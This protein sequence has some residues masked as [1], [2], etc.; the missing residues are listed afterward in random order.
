MFITVKEAAQIL[1]MKLHKVRYLLMMGEIEAVKISGRGMGRREA[2]RLS[3]D[4]VNEYVKRHPERET[5]EP[6]GNFIYTGNGGYLFGCVSDYLPLNTHEK[7]PCME[8][9]RR[10]LVHSA[11]RSD[12]V[13]LAKFKPVTQLELFSA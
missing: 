1:H 13:L 6:S 5:E 10:Q 9:R 12:K 3:A 11:Q 8:R 7:T 4:A 2:W